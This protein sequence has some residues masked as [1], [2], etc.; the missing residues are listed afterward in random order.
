MEKNAKITI[1]TNGV[2]AGDFIDIL[3]LAKDNIEMLQI[4]I[5]G[6]EIIHDKRRKNFSGK[7][8]FIDISKSIDALLDN[9]INTNAPT[10]Q[11]L[12]IR[13]GPC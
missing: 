5:D 8:S 12:L 6:P 13:L 2:F 10:S 9:K 1:V 4:T 11:V 3:S 7:G